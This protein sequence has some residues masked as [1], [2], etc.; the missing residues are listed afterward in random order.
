MAAASMIIAYI[1]PFLSTRIS[2]AHIYRMARSHCNIF[3]QQQNGSYFPNR[4]RYTVNTLRAHKLDSYNASLLKI[5]TISGNAMFT[6]CSKL[7]T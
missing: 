2:W 3:L 6:P 7:L 4:K 1:D 5:A